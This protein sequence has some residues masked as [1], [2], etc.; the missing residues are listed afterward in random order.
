MKKKIFFS[1]IWA[2]SSI[3]VYSSSIDINLNTNVPSTYATYNLY[4]QEE[5]IANETTDFSIETTS[6]TE[7]GQTES[8]SIVATSN[9]NSKRTIFIEIITNPFYNISNTSLSEEQ[10][11]SKIQPEAIFIS[12][13]YILEPGYNKDKK[14]S[15][16]YL[17]WNG[18]SNLD[19][20]DYQSNVII[21]YY[22]E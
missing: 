1:L 22:L 21:N 2:I 6:I 15:E 18:N 3:S 12:K 17:Q 10:A 7:S 14:V 9:L 5:L 16:F 19:S 13:D 4:Y 11:N 20:G 8:F